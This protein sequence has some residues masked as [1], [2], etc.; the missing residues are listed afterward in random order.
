MLAPRRFFHH[1][2][3]PDPTSFHIERAIRKLGSVT[4]RDVLH[5]YAKQPERFQCIDETEPFFSVLLRLARG[6]ECVAVV[7]DTP[8][9]AHS[10][11]LGTLSVLDAL[12]WL[13][14]DLTLL[15][16][17]RCCICCLSRPT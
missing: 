1:F 16:A 12:A 6:S 9:H 8:E 14:E 5:F 2:L 15:S 10:F 4:L 3:P 17:C 7:A 11:V 13:E